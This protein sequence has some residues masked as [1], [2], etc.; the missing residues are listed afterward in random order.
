MWAR[1]IELLVSIW[2]GASPYIV[3]HAERGDVWLTDV[4]CAL[5]V[6]TASLLSWLP[7]FSRAHLFELL[8]AVWLIGFGWLSAR[9]DPSPAHENQIVLGLLLA[10]LAI[11]PSRALDPPIS[12]R[13]FQSHH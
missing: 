3:Q 7:R 12:W 11:V 13:F 1:V 6:A 8:P 9:A 5:V 4:T 2:L 10:M